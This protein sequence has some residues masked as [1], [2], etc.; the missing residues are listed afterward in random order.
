VDAVSSGGA[1]LLLP[2]APVQLLVGLGRR[3]VLASELRRGGMRLRASRTRRCVSRSSRCSS[4]LGQ[5][6]FCARTCL[7]NS[8][9]MRF[10]AAEPCCFFQSRQYSSLSRWAVARSWRANWRSSSALRTESTLARRGAARTGHL[11]ARDAGRFASRS[12]TR[13]APGLLAMPRIIRG[14]LN[15][16]PIAGECCCGDCTTV[17]T[18]WR[19]SFANPLAARRAGGCSRPAPA[20]RS[21]SH[22]FFCSW[23]DVE[24]RAY[25][26]ARRFITRTSRHGHVVG[27]VLACC[28]GSPRLF[29]SVAAWKGRL[30]GRS[31]K[32]GATPLVLESRGAPPTVARA[33]ARCRPVIF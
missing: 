15:P 3:P 4:S 23:R 7:R 6:G 2:V 33:A 12:F 5:P 14:S 1:V 26:A 32:H 10:P 24:T 21:G 22:A 30:R 13:R 8:S 28:S 31:R 19:R 9:W 25:N 11:S 18:R 29:G 20:R 16:C 17:F 27:G